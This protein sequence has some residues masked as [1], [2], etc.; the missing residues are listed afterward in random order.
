M[1]FSCIESGPASFLN[2]RVMAARAGLAIHPIGAATFAAAPPIIRCYW[3]Y[4]S[5]P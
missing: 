3:A 1:S 4:R 2:F 5:A